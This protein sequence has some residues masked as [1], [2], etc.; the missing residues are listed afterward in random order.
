MSVSS[1]LEGKEG[2]IITASPRDSVAKVV[3]MLT[4]HRIG[5]VIV[6]DKA[7]SVKGIL[8]ERD[9]VR[10]VANSGANA[11]ENPVS[12][13]MTENVRTCSC[14]DTVNDLMKIMTDHHIRHMP[15]INDGKL[16]GMISIG[17]VV[18]RKIWQAEKDAQD[19]KDYIAS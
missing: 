8:S 11:L 13:L 10:D 3:G 9:V 4:K 17:D 6:C 19:L 7:G 2:R 14:N 16:V 15:V 12:A 1:I 5:A 18:K